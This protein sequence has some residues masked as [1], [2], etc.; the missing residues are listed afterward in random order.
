MITRTTYSY[1]RSALVDSQ[2]FRTTGFSAFKHPYNS[3]DYFRLPRF[4]WGWS[5]SQSRSLRKG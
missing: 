1:T 5:I 3:I 2:G 4:S